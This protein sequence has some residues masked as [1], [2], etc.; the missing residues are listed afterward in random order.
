M[1]TKQNT[2]IHVLLAGVALLAMLLLYWILARDGQPMLTPVGW[3]VFAGAALILVL[4]TF[5]PGLVRRMRGL[6]PQALSRSEITVCIAITA[7]GCLLAFVGVFFE[8]W[9]L[10][11]LGIMLPPLAFMPRSITTRQREQKS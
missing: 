11:A 9:W 10:M 4:A 7:I 1:K 5:L 2:T 8:V 6:P 3:L